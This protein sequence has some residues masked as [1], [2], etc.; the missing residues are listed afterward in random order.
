MGFLTLN[1][2]F[3]GDQQDV[4]DDRIDVVSRGLL[5]LTVTCA[6]CHDHKFDPIPTRDY[7]SLYGIFANSKEPVV[8]PVLEGRPRSL[9]TQYYDRE[10]CR[11]QTEL[12]DFLREKHR[13]LLEST[14]ARIAEYLIT[15]QALRDRPPTEAFME[16]AQQDDLNPVMLV[17]WRA[18]LEVTA[19]A[20]DPVFAPWQAL[21]AMP[22]AELPTKASAVIVR[23]IGSKVPGEQINPLVA[24]ELERRRPMSLTELAETYAQV[25]R[26]VDRQWQ[27]ALAGARKN[28]Q[29]DPVRLSDPAAEQ[30]RQVYYGQ[31]SPLN[32]P[33]NMRGDLALL[34]DRE[35]QAIR[36][37]L[38][39]DL[40]AWMGHAPGAPARAMVLQDASQPNQQFVFLR[41]NPT[42]L[43]AEA[44]PRFLECLSGPD[45]REFSHGSG[46]LELAEAIADPANPLTARVMVN[47]IWMHHFGAG[48]VRTPS[49]FGL[50]SDPPTHPELLDY[51]ASH[52]VESGWSIQKLHRLI[53][54]SA[55]YQQSSADRPDTKNID[56]ENLLLARMNRQRLDFEA[57]RDALL[58]VAGRLDPSIG[59][60]PTASVLD[61]SHP[62]RSLYACVDRLHLPGVY[63]T[64]DF[65]NPDTTSPRR[66]ITTVPQQALFWM[67][68]PFVREMAR[69]VATAPALTAA[70]PLDRK[71]EW[72]Y[73]RLY[74]R[75]SR[76]AERRIAQE[77]LAARSDTAA[78]QDY[79]QAL[80]LANEFVFI[81]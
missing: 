76:P 2:W 27:E 38:T 73:E 10:L 12:G 22:E 36:D 71:V 50:R 4:L 51:L 20:F 17:R 69:S 44:P 58:A 63:R 81:D 26:D 35:S 42:R 45:R 67:N 80:L 13:T 78:W 11:R 14:R 59:G 52:F 41:G 6:R 39:Q 74:G 8:P 64:F 79:S 54:L 77:F 68:S 24:R 9:V 49:D 61:A 55:V 29:P 56:P 57:M 31:H 65:P 53:M 37:H 1:N 28:G 70:A 66:D 62:R 25:L 33:F 3:N 47:R 46:R 75:G 34:P 32:F 48:L 40:Q 5:G 19:K 7:Y 21:V 60:P 23:L 16:I 72:L 43:G 30:L 18:Y 15:A